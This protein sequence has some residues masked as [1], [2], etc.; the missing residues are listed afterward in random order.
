MPTVGGIG[1]YHYKINGF[2]GFKRPLFSFLS[3]TGSR[4]EGG[5][6]GRM[7]QHIKK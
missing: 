2:N 7:V 1:V 3:L 5:G 6:R 4:V